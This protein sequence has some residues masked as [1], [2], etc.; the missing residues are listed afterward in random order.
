MFR[1]FSSAVE[2]NKRFL[3]TVCESRR[4][5]CVAWLL[6]YYGLM[7][8]PKCGHQLSDAE[9]VREAASIQGRKGGKAAKARDP[10]KM[11]EAGRLGGLAKA[12]NRAAEAK[13]AKAKERKA[14]R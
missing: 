9:I 1:H 2:L 10:E 3:S 7:Q 14:K 11:R 6:G 5:L 8:C 13:L 12:R 4:L